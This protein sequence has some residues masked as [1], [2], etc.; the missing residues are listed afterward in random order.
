[1]FW[2]IC[3]ERGQYAAQLF[4]DVVGAFDAVLRQ[5]LFGKEHMPCDD[6]TIAQIVRAMGFGPE[7]MH[8]IT[9]V[10][11]ESSLM[12][13]LGVS[14]VLA[15]ATAEAHMH[16]WFSTQGLATIVRARSGS[17]PGDPLGDIIFS[18]LEFKVH[19]EIRTELGEESSTLKVPPL[20]LHVCPAFH[21]NQGDV[22]ALENNY[23][24]DDAFG[25]VAD[26]PSALIPSVV[27]VVSVVA[28]VF[29]RHA[30]PLNWKANKTEVIV[31]IRGAGKKAVLKEITFDHGSVLKIPGGMVA[32]GSPDI[33]LRVVTHY[34]HMGRHAAARH[35][36]VAEAKMRAG[37]MYV[38]YRQLRSK[39]FKHTLAPRQV[40]VGLTKS[41]QH[42]RL[43]FG[44]ALWHNVPN[45]A[46]RIMARAYVSPLREATSMQN[47]G[48]QFE[49]KGSIY[50][51]DAQ[52]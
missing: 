45:Q 20:P 35:D 11:R 6:G 1:M 9:A 10:V 23:V 22:M 32:E 18:F 8:E 21:E 48:K 3:R 17:R 26:K 40:R 5:N 7:T 15:D 52:V 38:A 37:T 31:D 24:D 44:C 25:I 27:R 43:L 12:K 46:W 33:A 29:A 51:Y 30:L 19:G 4:V 14:T 28:R 41:L 16:T 13:D 42:S 2:D 50:T 39:V 34:K 36:M 49:A 47:A